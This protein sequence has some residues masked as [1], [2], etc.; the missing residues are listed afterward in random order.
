LVCQQTRARF[1]D[2]RVTDRFE[3]AGFSDRY[4]PFDDSPEARSTVHSDHIANTRRA[5]STVA[6]AAAAI[7]RSSVAGS[8]V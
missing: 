5:E 1:E 2:R 4:W 8:P 3:G 7:L 6:A